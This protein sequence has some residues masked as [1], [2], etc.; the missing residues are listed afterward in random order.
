M[1]VK[2]RGHYRSGSD[3]KDIISQPPI[4][5]A[6]AQQKVGVGLGD[7]KELDCLQKRQQPNT[8]LTLDYSLVFFIHSPTV[9]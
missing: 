5:S 3:Y 2:V 1:L 4:L 8:Q 9:Y 6:T 7:G